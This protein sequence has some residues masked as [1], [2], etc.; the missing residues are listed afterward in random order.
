MRPI[1]TL[2]ALICCLSQFAQAQNQPIQPR[3]AIQDKIKAID[4]SLKPELNY[5]D[6]PQQIYRA[7]QTRVIVVNLRNSGRVAAGNFT[8]E[9]TYNWRVDHESFSAQTL[10]RSQTINGLAADQ[11]TQVEFVVPDS[12]IRRNAPYGSPN[13]SISIKIDASGV[14]AEMQENNNLASMSLPI[15]NP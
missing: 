1:I 7:P 10:K 15:L 12:L 2:I 5:N 8:L 13:V 11:Q 14:V 9:V 6:A 3:L 4:L